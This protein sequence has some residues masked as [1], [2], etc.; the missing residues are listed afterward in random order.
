MRLRCDL[1]F[2][3]FVFVVSHSHGYDPLKLMFSWKSLEFDFP[4][5]QD[6]QWAIDN[7][8]FIRGTLVP[9]DVDVYNKG[10]QSSKVFITIPRFQSG[11]PLT[12]GYVTGRI[13]SE[14]NPV[15]APYPDWESNTLGDCDHLTSVYRIM[16]DECDRLWVLDTGRLI[17]KQICPP[18]ILVFNL[19][20]NALILRYK[21]PDDTW[22]EDSLPVT[23]AVDIRDSHASCRDTF[24][25]IADVTG[26][27]LIVYSLRLNRSWKISN[28]LF[29]PYPPRGTFDIDGEYFDLMDGILGMTL[30]PMQQNGDRILYFH[31]L[32][33][34][35]ESWV[36][37][38]VIRNPQTFEENPDA[39]PRSFKSFEM[40]RPSQSAAE[41]MD[42]NGVLFFGLMSELA[43]G[44]WNSKRYPAFGGYNNEIIVVNR[45][46]LQFASGMKVVTARNGK[47]ELWVLTSS[48]QKY[49]TGTLNPNETNFRIQAGYVDDLVRGTKCDPYRSYSRT[50]SLQFLSTPN[51]RVTL[52]S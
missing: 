51:N 33:S 24:V 46:T 6:R 17:S 49:M 15:I 1:L 8:Q 16:V 2:L 45:Q 20:T 19:N 7:G 12:L 21:F 39:T 35:V 47:Q 48:F 9:I 28:K 41:A 50:S 34:D 30:G 31:S 11:V 43:I 44:C 29:Y 37:T 40:T 18:Q 14:G 52:S 10:P 36:P 23:M 5:E 3:L 38:S 25:Y 32:A 27:Q 42:R 22:K 4:S 26:F 13:T